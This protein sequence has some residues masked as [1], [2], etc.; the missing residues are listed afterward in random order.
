MQ[1]LGQVLGSRAEGYHVARVCVRERIREAGPRLPVDGDAGGGHDLQALRLRPV[2]PRAVRVSRAHGD[3]IGAVRLKAGRDA[4][5]RRSRRGGRL[6]FPALEDLAVAIQPSL[7]G[8]GVPLGIEGRRPVDHRRD[9][10]DR[11]QDPAH[12]Q[13]ASGR[14]IGA[15]EV[16]LQRSGFGGDDQAPVRDHGRRARRA[17]DSSRPEHGT[18]RGAQDPHG[19]RQRRRHRDQRGCPRARSRSRQ[20]LVHGRCGAQPVLRDVVERGNHRPAVRLLPQH[21]TVGGAHGDDRLA[22]QE[23]IRHAVIIRVQGIVAPQVEDQAAG[24][25]RQRGHRQL[26][27]HQRAADVWRGH[28]HLHG[29]ASDSLT[30]CQLDGMDPAAATTGQQVRAAIHDHRGGEVDDPVRLVGPPETSGREIEA[31]VVTLVGADDHLIAIRCRGRIAE[32][33]QNLGRRFPQCVTRDGV[34]PEQ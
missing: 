12:Q 11:Q 19:G 23:L 5:R 2:G 9:I 24:K 33:R 34:D 22:H 10:T 7:V 15:R 6:G 30:A 4:P 21:V 18:A 26:A 31:V 25:R 13:R 28:R 32:L 27:S 14:L 1:R 8:D 17:W 29:P 16:A 3:Q 20:A